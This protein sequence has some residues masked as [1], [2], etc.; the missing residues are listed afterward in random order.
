MFSWTKEEPIAVNVDHLQEYHKIVTRTDT[1]KA[2]NVGDYVR[3]KSRPFLPNHHAG[4]FAETTTIQDNDKLHGY[5][6]GFRDVDQTKHAK[7]GYLCDMSIAVVSDGHVQIQ[8]CDSRLFYRANDADVC[9]V[10]KEFAQ[11]ACVSDVSPGM[12]VR[13]R[14]HAI[15]SQCKEHTCTSSWTSMIFKVPLMVVHV[16]G[17]NVTVAGITNSAIVEEITVVKNLLCAI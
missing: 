9:P 3:L 11:D 2:V 15:I 8:V 7:L 17:S 13:P 12:L 5:V 16:A 6:I 10:L 4:C 1:Y 14:A